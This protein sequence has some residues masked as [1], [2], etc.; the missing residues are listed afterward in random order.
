[1]KKII[2]IIFILIITLSLFSCKE[3]GTNNNNNNTKQNIKN[4]AE[5]IKIITPTVSFNTHGGT[6][7]EPIKTK[8]LNYEPQTAKENY[9]FDGWYLDSA[10]NTPAAFPLEIK[11]DTVL[12]AKW[13]VIKEKATC[14][15]ASLKL[16]T[17]FENTAIYKITPNGFDM[18]RLKELGYKMKITVT[19]DVYYRKD[20]DVLFDIG[21]FGAPKYEATLLDSKLLG[22]SQLNVK[23]TES[24]KT[25]TLSYS[26]TIADI[27]KETFTLTFHTDNIQNVVHFN[28]ISITYECYK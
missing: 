22:D 13:L 11:Y 1:M 16:D 25:K 23:A 18:N 20:Y 8:V 15:D 24:T 2:S 12:H 6:E 7:I 10:Y 5:E 4:F 3:N 9:V 21:Y 26:G 17:S 19:Y 28:D 14:K 27:E